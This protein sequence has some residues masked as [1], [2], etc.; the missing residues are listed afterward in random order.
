M[1]ETLTSLGGALDN[2][3]F[4]WVALVCLLAIWKINGKLG[5][6]V[7]VMGGKCCTP[8]PSVCGL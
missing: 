7:V 5:G 1:L 3:R 4:W 6:Y 8:L 2:L